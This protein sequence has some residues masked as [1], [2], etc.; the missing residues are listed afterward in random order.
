MPSAEL[1]RACKEATAALTKVG[2]I[3]RDEKDGD[4]TGTEQMAIFILLK[5]FQ[6]VMNPLQEEGD[7]DDNPFKYD[8]DHTFT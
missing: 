2:R 3:L 1:V 8:D 6:F 5:A 7:D 4:L